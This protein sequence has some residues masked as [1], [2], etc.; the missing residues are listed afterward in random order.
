MAAAAYVRALLAVTP[1]T[2][3]SRR[4]P[5]GAG[6][7]AGWPRLPARPRVAATF[8]GGEAVYRA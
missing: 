1:D 7:T 3:G 8:V 2:A 6:R 4:N 5:A